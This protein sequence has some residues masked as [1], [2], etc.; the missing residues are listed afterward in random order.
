VLAGRHFKLDL[1]NRFLLLLVY[2]HL[3]ITYTLAVGFL[4]NWDQSNM[5]K[6]IQKIESL[7]RQCLPV[8][9][10]TYCKTK[11]LKTIEEV[12]KYYPNFLSFIDCIE[13]QIPMPID[14]KRKM[15]FYSG[16]KKTHSVKNQIM[17]NNR[18]YILHKDSYKK[19][20]RHDYDIEYIRRIICHSQKK[21]L[22][23]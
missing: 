12:E 14:N 15:I 7:I 23:L 5:Y 18:G 21:R 1:E 8:P 9:P 6:D 11:M 16:K 22:L 3:Y 20:K 17:V 2:Y 13:K 19:G 10:K 4:F